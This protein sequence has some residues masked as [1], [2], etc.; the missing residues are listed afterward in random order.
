MSASQ[1]YTK[2]NK[3]K[4]ITFSGVPTLVASP[5]LM[6]YLQTHQGIIQFQHDP[7]TKTIQPSLIIPHPQH[8]IEP[9]PPPSQETRMCKFIFWLYLQR[10]FFV[11]HLKFSFSVSEKT[12][13]IAPNNI[14]TPSVQDIAVNRSQRSEL[15][16]SV[17]TTTDEQ[18]NNLNNV[19][20]VQNSVLVNPNVVKFNMVKLV[21]DNPSLLQL[22]TEMNNL[23]GYKERNKNLTG[24][25]V[26]ELDK[27]I[28]Q[29]RA[30]LDQCFLMENSRGN[31]VSSATVQ[32]V[33]I[34]DSVKK[35]TITYQV[36]NVT[37]GEKVSPMN[38]K[39]TE[40]QALEDLQNL[41]MTLMKSFHPP[42]STNSPAPNSDFQA[43]FLESIGMASKTPV[44]ATVTIGTGTTPVSPSIASVTPTPSQSSSAM[45]RGRKKKEKIQNQAIQADVKADIPSLT[46]NIAELT[47]EQNV[48]L[49][50]ALQNRGAIINQIEN[51]DAIKQIIHEEV[52]KITSGSMENANIRF[53]SSSGV[54][55]DDR[56][57][58]EQCVST[59]NVV[60]SNSQVL[61]QTSSQNNV[62]SLQG[63]ELVAIN[64]GNQQIYA[65]QNQVLTGNHF[66]SSNNQIL[67]IG[68]SHNQLVSL[69]N[70]IN[71]SNQ[72]VTLGNSSNLMS[73]GGSNVASPGAV[74]VG[75][76]GNV[77][78]IVHQNSPS[79]QNPGIVQ[80]IQ[81]IQLTA[82]KQQVRTHYCLHIFFNDDYLLHKPHSK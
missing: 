67:T 78:A 21:K 45:K 63:N 80:R 33:I 56:D 34:K 49:N 15:K 14:R 9:T 13:A 46:F 2:F 71:S 58:S 11:L 54:A 10:K 65:S 20:S 7:V 82:P 3:K 52:R 41:D 50:Q 29:N 4:F 28:Q 42:Q 81:T 77:V 74:I 44:K 73:V 30:I 37:I 43:K 57:T 16:T 70:P 51:L 31:Q 35:E 75:S 18:K 48:R 64:S 76:N 25:E 1:S 38:D 26:A 40:T 8:K 5:A 66:V 12:A 32:N 69:G 62:I 17:G 59:A 23:I 47:P 39:T 72:I 6:Q 60:L 27:K 53:T 79:G 68:G 24:K 61:E 19:S 55:T 36:G 22:A